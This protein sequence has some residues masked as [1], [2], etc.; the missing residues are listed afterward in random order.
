MEAL[1]QELNSPKSV[2]ISVLYVKHKYFLVPWHYHPE[3]EILLILKGEGRRFVGDHIENFYEGDLCLIGSELPHVWKSK[4]EYR[5]SRQEINAECLVIHFRNEMF[6]KAFGELVELSGIAELLKSSSRG[7]KFYGETRKLLSELIANTLG[8]SPEERLIILLKILNMM[9]QT[10]E[11]KY[12]SSTSFS[13]EI[14]SFDGQRFQKIVEF[15][16]ANY[17][18]HIQLSELAEQI[19]MAPTA[20]CRYF[21]N[22]TGKSF[23]QYL[24]NYRIGLARRLLIEDRLNIQEI[25]FECGF[26]N[27]SHFNTQFKKINGTTP[28]EFRKQ[29]VKTHYKPEP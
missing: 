8:A 28:R 15:I 19:H 25:A 26:G 11:C 14:Y 22:R 2:S 13:Q 1:F 17:H 10:D 3:N 7:I 6:G 24:N 4:D 5:N 23:L 12:L 27:L 18:R 9:A 29:H 20:F 16:S 21:K